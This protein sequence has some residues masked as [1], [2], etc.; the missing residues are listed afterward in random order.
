MMTKCSLLAL[1][2]GLS[3]ILATGASE[4]RGAQKPEAEAGWLTAAEAQKDFDFLRRVLEEAHPGLYRYVEKAEMDHVFDSQ[5]AKL[6]RPIKRVDFMLTT[7]ETVAAIRCGHTSIRPDEELAGQMESARKFPFRVRI[8]GERLLVLFNDTPN[9]ETIRPGSEILEIN[10]HKVSDLI[11]RFWPLESGDGDIETGKRLHIENAFALYYWAGVGPTNR[12]LILARDPEGKTLT[13]TLDGVT[14]GERKKNQNPANA[15]VQAVVRKINWSSENEALRFMKDPDVAEVRLRYF[16]GDKFPQWIEDTFK[17][18]RDKGTKT[19][20]LDLRGNG[21]G[22]DGYGAKVVSCLTDKPFR[23]FSQINIKVLSPSFKEQS[24]W[25]GGFEA[26]LRGG[27]IPDAKVGY[28]VTPE[29]HPCLS[30]QAPGRFP[31]LGKVIVLIN[32]GTFSTAADV[33]AVLHHLK[34]A[35]FVGEETG[36]GYYGNN[37]GPM[38]MVTLPASHLALRLPM[39]EYWN[40]VPGYDGKRR[41]TIP[42]YVV[43]IKT[44]DLLKGVDATLDLALK[45]AAEGALRKRS[46]ASR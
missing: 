4:P 46:A 13:A 25:D 2:T 5:R 24:D 23:Y 11:R 6:D 38:P 16:V 8:E 43:E 1:L 39:Y 45:L 12:F 9:D 44:A 32:G 33:C 3:Q 35:Q 7:L 27:T 28:R 18:L 19:L 30:E 42:D 37:S 40:E 21:G 36:G 26:K 22:E 29:L 10:G 15:A 17:S 14:D 20:I 31:F 34:R 41:G